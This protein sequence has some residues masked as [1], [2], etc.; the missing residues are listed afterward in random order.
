M[1]IKKLQFFI[2]IIIVLSTTVV[3]YGDMGPKPSIE[4]IVN[5]G[6]DEI[7]YMDL[8]VDYGKDN[9]HDNIKN[10][11]NY[12]IS[13]INKLK[14]HEKN[15]WHLALLTGSRAPIWGDIKLIGINKGEFSYVGV[16]DKFKIIIVTKDKKVVVSNVINRKAFNSTIYFDYNSKKAYEKSMYILYLKNIIFTFTATLL[17]EGLILILFK[18][19]LKKNLKPLILVNLLTQIL[20]TIVVIRT[21]IRYG[22]INAFI[23]YVLFEMCILFI[24]S[25]LYK[26]YLVGHTNKRIIIYAIVANTVSFLVGIKLLYV[27][28]G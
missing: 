11:K 23:S 3:S 7:M 27:I 18:F 21:M 17:I 25:S 6:P 14:E 5:N 28:G 12:D 22:T 19:D 10:L 16:P 13:M 20:L 24:E 2:V 4:I 1:I 8:L 9:I 15:G 26:K